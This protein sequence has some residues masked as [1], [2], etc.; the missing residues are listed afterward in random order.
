MAGLTYFGK[1]LDE[2]LGAS[3]AV[4]REV[5]AAS[6]FKILV[7]AYIR[8]FPADRAA[9]SGL[10]RNLSESLAITQ[11]G[12]QDLYELAK[13][14]WLM[15]EALNARKTD[16]VVIGDLK[17]IASDDWD[18]MR[19]LLHPSVRSIGLTWNV[20]D[21]VRG[22]FSGEGIR[23]LLPVEGQSNVVIR[24]SQEMI[25][26]R[27]LLPDEAAAFELARDDS[28]FRD[29]CDRLRQWHESADC[30]DR[31]TAMI[32]RWVAD[33]CIS[34]IELESDGRWFDLWA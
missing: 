23:P 8:D 6:D 7:D 33:E 34:D 22:Y 2:A 25:V 18:G 4:L 32:E 26:W 14:E 5:L 21:V 12:R 3:F 24:R 27:S 28:P 11:P 29:I 30:R 13:F 15:R 20:A 17:Y 9:G 10:G 16:L 19:L 31:A 1:S